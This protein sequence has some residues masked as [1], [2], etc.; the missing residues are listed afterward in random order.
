MYYN[1]SSLMK[2]LRFKT[3]LFSIFCA[4]FALF[5]SACMKPVDLP[6]FLGDDSVL[7]FIDVVQPPGNLVKLIDPP[8]GI[9]AGF[10][11]IT[12][13][14]PNIYYMLEEY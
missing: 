1:S 6:R 11:R 5:F 3:V 13:L 12:G 7:D 8:D 14:R 9:T 10:R 4:F 2:K